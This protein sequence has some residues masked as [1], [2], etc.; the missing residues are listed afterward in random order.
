[1]DRSSPQ[2]LRWM[3]VL[4]LTNLVEGLPLSVPRPNLWAFDM[5]RTVRYARQPQRIHLQFNIH[6]IVPC[7]WSC[8]FLDALH[9]GGDDWQWGWQCD[10]SW[11]DYGKLDMIWH[12][13][14]LKPSTD[15][16]DTTGVQERFKLVKWAWFLHEVV[17]T[18]STL[19]WLKSRPW[20]LHQS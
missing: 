19:G 13:C 7:W 10:L 14:K 2:H 8:C 20:S 1:M 16:Q 18:C 11:N 17:L 3:V 12:F 6:K 9:A 15:P 4:V 5:W